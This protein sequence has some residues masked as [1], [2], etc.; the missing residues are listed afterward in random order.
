MTV[1]SAAMLSSL[2]ALSLWAVPA[3]AQVT[4]AD[5]SNRFVRAAATTDGETVF[6]DAYLLSLFARP[7]RSIF[8]DFDKTVQGAGLA[9]SN[10]LTAFADQ[11]S[12]LPH[13]LNGS[14]A[15]PT[16]LEGSASIAAVLNADD[17]FQGFSL[18]SALYYFTVEEETWLRI[19]WDLSA[20]STFGPVGP[21]HYASLAIHMGD[22]RTEPAL[23][24]RVV[25]S[26][27]TDEGYSIMSF[28]PGLYA[29]QATALANIANSGT[30][31]EDF[32]YPSEISRTAAYS[33]S[34]A[35]VPAPA[36]LPFAAIGLV[37]ARRRRR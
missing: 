33:V 25:G 35:V 30:A 7:D 18:S 17:P 22:P 11:R 29:L 37:V 23:F 16:R 26:G 14:E 10:A 12:D 32:E 19:T 8:G 28:G 27:E 31:A 24:S 9:G 36:T 3:R 15:L 2:S 6:N 5:S 13:I 34:F 1:F 21:E 20:S 4:F